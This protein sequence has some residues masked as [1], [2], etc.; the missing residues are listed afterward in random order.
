MTTESPDPNPFGAGTGEV[1]LLMSP[2]RTRLQ[3]RKLASTRTETIATAMTAPANKGSPSLPKPENI[4]TAIGGVI[5][6]LP[7]NVPISLTKL[8]RND[9]KLLL[10]KRE[11]LRKHTVAKQEGLPSPVSSAVEA[12]LVFAQEEAGTAVCIAPEGL[13]LTCSHCVAERRDELDP[14]KLHWL[15]FASGRIVSAKCVA[16]D[17]ARDLA[18]LQVVASQA[19]ASVSSVGASTAPCDAGSSA[20]SSVVTGDSTTAINCRLV[21]I[22]HPGSEDLEAEEPGV[23]TDYDVLHV[24]TGRFRGH[25]EG[26]D[27]QDNSEIGALQHDC[28]TYWGHS[29]APLL[30]RRSGKLV[31]LHSSWDDETGMRRGVPLVAIQAFLRESLS[32]GHCAV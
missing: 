2:R 12:T 21:C 9:H 17:P 13:L 3:R 8:G 27:P 31:G 11:L 1:A 28:W 4:S 23:K 20:F 32:A 10:R 15:I 22:G 29:G 18:L 16:W 26:Q 14:E 24:S 6:T 5:R 7:E 30:D 19:D 25:A